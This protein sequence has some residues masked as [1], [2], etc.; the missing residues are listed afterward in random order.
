M[1]LGALANPPLNGYEIALRNL[2]CSS[3]R[4]MVLATADRETIPNLPLAL[5]DRFVQAGVA[6]HG[7][8]SV[9]ADLA[10]RG[11]IPIVHAP[12]AFLT[13][14]AFAFL[15]GAPELAHLPIKL[16]GSVPGV[17]S[18]VK[19]AAH[20][21]FEDVA[22]MRLIPSMQLFCP[23]DEQ[24]LLFGL[25]RLLHS[26]HPLYVRHTSL[27]AVTSHHPAFG[28]GYAEEVLCGSDVTIFV[29]G[30]LFAQAYE[31]TMLLE[32]DGCSVR[33]F[34]MRMLQPVDTA[35]IVRAARETPLVVTIEDHSRTGGLF[36][37]VSELLQ[38]RG[39]RVPV[40]PLNLGR[41]PIP[42][43]RLPAILYDQGF[44]GPQLAARIAG[45]LQRHYD[46]LP[47]ERSH[48]LHA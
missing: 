26:P 12:A 32:N 31:A 10:Q 3:D 19:G 43:G 5:G 46:P 45:E 22:L 30:S 9:A 21:S 13:M 14:R 17:I 18:A 34:N 48:F 23:A 35:A 2:V 29:Y 38:Q 27:A 1:S 7:L 15:R 42:L 20:A 16:V 47:S 44:T 41:R 39:I 25:S 4:F 33:L 24:D 6:G 11:C 8:L 28:I 37:I 36:T 40:M